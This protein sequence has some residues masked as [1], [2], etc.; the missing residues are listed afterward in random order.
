[1]ANRLSVVIVDDRSQD[2]RNLAVE[3]EEYFDFYEVAGIDD[4]ATEIAR[5]NGN[6]R[7]IVDVILC[8]VNMER[9]ESAGEFTITTKD[10]CFLVEPNF[11]MSFGDADARSGDVA[12]SDLDRSH[13]FKPYGPL[14]ALPFTQ[15]FSG[16]GV[17]EPISAFWRDSRLIRRT[18]LEGGGTAMMNGYAYVAL[19]LIWDQLETVDSGGQDDNFAKRLSEAYDRGVARTGNV[20]IERLKRATA[21]RREQLFAGAKLV[22]GLDGATARGLLSESGDELVTIW[23]E[24]RPARQVRRNSLFGDFAI[25]MRGILN[26]DEEGLRFIPNEEEQFEKEVA[27]APTHPSPKRIRELCESFVGVLSSEEPPTDFETLYHTALDESGGSDATLPAAHAPRELPSY[28]RRYL[29]LTAQLY[30]ASLNIDDPDRVQPEAGKKQGKSGRSLN[31]PTRKALGLDLK[32][33]HEPRDFIYGKRLNAEQAIAASNAD[34]WLRPFW[35]RIDS[36]TI[37]ADGWQAFNIR[38]TPEQGEHPDWTAL[39]RWIGQA[40]W[41]RLNQPDPCLFEL[42]GPAII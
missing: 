38:R 40:V 30:L 28:L 23:D 39:D 11:A 42:G 9:D 32:N 3:A 16:G 8:D 19:R 15:F 5:L 10:G 35:P 36:S 22:A 13:D 33:S 24:Y 7:P 29:L 12:T 4:V 18:D 1:M 20:M 27:K 25:R 21:R 17:T 37:E 31:V 6:P 14:L 34:P 26:M 2:S 41:K